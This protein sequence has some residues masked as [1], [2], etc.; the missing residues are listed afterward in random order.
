MNYQTKMPFSFR[1]RLNHNGAVNDFVSI[2]CIY[3]NLFETKMIPF[4]CSYDNLYIDHVGF[5]ARKKLVVS[6]KNRIRKNQKL[7]PFF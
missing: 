3:Y 4:I 2:Y 6:T 5:L 1:E 7:S